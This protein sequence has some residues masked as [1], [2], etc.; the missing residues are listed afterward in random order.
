[1][2]K[3]L[4]NQTTYD[5]CPCQKQN[6]YNTDPTQEVG[7][8]FLPFNQN[9]L[10][11]LRTMEKPRRVQQNR[12]ARAG[13]TDER[14]RPHSSHERVLRRTA[15]PTGLVLCRPRTGRRSNQSPCFRGTRSWGKRSGMKGCVQTHTPATEGKWAGASAEQGQKR[16]TAVK[17]P[18]LLGRG[19]WRQFYWNKIFCCLRVTTS[20]TI[21]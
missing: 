13:C 16:V 19:S 5:C 6:L 2:A 21:C 8:V 9:P 1:M 18:G 11:P 15:T 20:R 14:T 7:M 3:N 4:K 10:E 17:A 12:M